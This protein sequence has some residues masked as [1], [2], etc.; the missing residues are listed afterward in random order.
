MN[1]QTMIAIALLLLPVIVLFALAIR[2]VPEYQRLVVFRLGRLIGEKGPGLVLLIP[3]VD[4]GVRVDL[5]E[6]FFDVPP[7]TCITKDNAQV[8]IDFLVYM[9]IVEALPSVLNVEF[10]GG[11]ARGIAMTTLRAVVGD[12]MLD[13]VLSKREQI[14]E[15]LR[16]KLDDVTSRWGIKVNA[17][18]IREIM[19]PREIQEAMAR[20]MSA[21]RSR[22]SM[23]I[24]AEGTR[25]KTIRV[26]DGEKQAQILKAEGMRQAEILKAEGFALALDKI[27]KIAS[28]VDSKTMSLQYLDT[29]KAL[30]ASTST[31]FIL[32]MEFTNLV[33]PFLQHTDSSS[34]SKKSGI[35]QATD[36]KTA[37]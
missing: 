35:P 15:G 33:R 13:E 3:V 14:N 7:Q 32:P 34:M 5:R 22:R 12:M 1:L 9:K 27:F 37:A 4:R 26:A 11:A 23:V 30:G 6:T 29:L 2:I 25:E 17:V 10:H 19:P 16:G 24:E 20:Q 31:K 21:E 8:S 36:R 28:S 18:E